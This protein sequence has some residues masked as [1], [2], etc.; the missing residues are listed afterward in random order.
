MVFFNRNTLAWENG[1][2]EI[3]EIA[4]FFYSKVN[5]LFKPVHTTSTVRNKHE[6]LEG[7]DEVSFDTPFIMQGH[8]ESMKK[9][10]RAL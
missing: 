7:K 6:K 4:T 2:F 1:H 3:T 8:A 10:M 9:I 5:A